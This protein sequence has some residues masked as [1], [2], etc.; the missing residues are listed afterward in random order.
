MVGIR[1]MEVPLNGWAGRGGDEEDKA[2]RRMIER[3][4]DN[5][6]AL[7]RVSR[8]GGGMDVVV[9]REGKVG[10][11][12]RGGKEA[13]P[14]ESGGSVLV[15]GEEEG[16]KV[17]AS[18]GVSRGACNGSPEGV[19]EGG[20]VRGAEVKVMN[21]VGGKGDV[22]RVKPVA[23]WTGSEVEVGPR[24]KWWWC[25]GVGGNGDR[26]IELEEYGQGG[27]VRWCRGIGVGGGRG[28]SVVGG[29]RV[30]RGRSGWARG[31]GVEGNG[32][33]A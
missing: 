33:A 13:V 17:G 9:G 25:S 28:L 10:G 29:R 22:S 16:E 30:E 31:R 21:L 11:V 20:R 12:G 19:V 24:R 5:V 1:D 3:G 32:I 14:M 2:G 26:R 18:E 6:Y 27:W 4:E 15:E 7:A 23:R 8:W